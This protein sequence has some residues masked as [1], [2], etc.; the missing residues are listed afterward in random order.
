M[1]FL[2]AKIHELNH[3][4]NSTIVIALP[5]ISTVAPFSFFSLSCDEI[6]SGEKFFFFYSSLERSMPQNTVNKRKF[7][8]LFITA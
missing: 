4:L 2:K 7:W 1:F 8:K 6:L 3:F 5:C